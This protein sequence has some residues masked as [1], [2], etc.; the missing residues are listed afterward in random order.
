[1]KK[2]LVVHPFLLGLFPIVFLFA[3]NKDVALLSETLLP[4]AGVLGFRIL[5]ILPLRTSLGSS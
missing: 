3:I 1:V 4:S 2:P 5:M